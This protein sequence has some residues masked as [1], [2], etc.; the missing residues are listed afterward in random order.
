MRRVDPAGIITTIAGTGQPGY[1]GDEHAAA[2][3]FGRGHA[4]H[5]DAVIEDAVHISDG[6]G[7]KAARPAAP[8]ESK[9]ANLRRRYMD[10]G[11]E[12]VRQ[13]IAGFMSLAPCPTCGGAR[14]NPVALLKRTDLGEIEDVVDDRPARGAMKD[15][16]GR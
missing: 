6:G 1:S 10:T 12:A 16:D 9:L 8:L 13:K 5:D 7:A 15:L 11:S 2:G 14:L 3:G 4:V